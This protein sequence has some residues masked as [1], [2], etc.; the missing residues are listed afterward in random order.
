MFTTYQQNKQIKTVW[1]KIQKKTTED[2][3]QESKLGDTTL[4]VG[5]S[6]QFCLFFPTVTL[7]KGQAPLSE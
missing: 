1:K 7:P 4:R 5:V 3:G 2:E 6:F